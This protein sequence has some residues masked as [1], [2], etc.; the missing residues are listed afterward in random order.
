M[1]GDTLRLRAYAKINWTLEVLGRR[2]DGYHEVRSILQTVALCDELEITFGV[3][4]AAPVIDVVQPE[5]WEVPADAA[6]LAARAL[7]VARLSRGRIADDVA[8]Q[9][10]KHIPPAAGLGGGSSDAAAVLRGAAPR[11]GLTAPDLAALASTLGSDVPFFLRGGTQLAGGR[12]ELLE[13]LP[14]LP[15]TWLVLVTP[16]I[17]LEEKTRRLYSLLTPASFSDGE[18]TAAAARAIRAGVMPESRLLRNAFQRVSERAFPELA[19]SLWPFARECGAA[20]LCGAGPSFFAVAAGRDEALHSVGRLVELGLP[21]RAVRTVS[22]AES[23]TIAG[24]EASGCY[25][26]ERARTPRMRRD[27]GTY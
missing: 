17:R 6:N 20:V 12:G 14:D 5:G 27:R 18:A 19:A 13:P 7:E 24:S 3:H 15:E 11:W 2:S 4:A 25:T 26:G 1:T 23:T 10:R 9:L 21:A 16:R 8:L 22:A